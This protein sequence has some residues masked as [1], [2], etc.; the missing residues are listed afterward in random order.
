MSIFLAIGGIRYV[1][2]YRACLSNFAHICILESINLTPLDIEG[3]DLYSLGFQMRFLDVVNDEG[4]EPD[5]DF[6]EGGESF[7][8]SDAF[9]LGVE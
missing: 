8:E 9:P 3:G 6:A 4:A 2:A 5:V 1:G 7:W